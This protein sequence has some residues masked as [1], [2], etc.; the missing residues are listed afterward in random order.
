MSLLEIIP[1]LELLSREKLLFAGHSSDDPHRPADD[2]P[3]NRSPAACGAPFMNSRYTKALFQLIVGT[4]QAFHIVALE[5][6][7]REVLGDLTEMRDAFPERSQLSL[8]VL[9]LLHTCQ[10]AFLHLCPGVLRLIGQD[11]RRLAHQERGSL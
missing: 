10:I 4:R 8:V 6:T 1:R 11:L 2:H 3:R 5:E 7:R 9:H